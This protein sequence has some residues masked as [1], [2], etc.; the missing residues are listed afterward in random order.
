MQ[1]VIVQHWTM[2]AS[3]AF[4]LR[5]PLTAVGLSEMPKTSPY[6]ALIWAWV[7]SRDVVID[8]SRSHYGTT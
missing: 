5:G 3:K 7:K 6:I 1:E 2:S 4:S 8:R